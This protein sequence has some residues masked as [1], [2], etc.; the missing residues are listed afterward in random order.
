MLKKKILANF[1]PTRY[2]PSPHYLP[3]SSCWWS[4]QRWETAMKPGQYQD[5]LY[6]KQDG[7]RHRGTASLDPSPSGSLAT[8]HIILINFPMRRIHLLMWYMVHVCVCM[9]E[10]DD[11]R[12]GCVHPYLAD[13]F[14]KL[15]SVSSRSSFGISRRVRLRS[16]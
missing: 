11:N 7:G 13:H 4:L 8:E 5:N 9:R 15:M 14:A 3:R 2:P 6:S 12:E 16:V 10:R 1:T